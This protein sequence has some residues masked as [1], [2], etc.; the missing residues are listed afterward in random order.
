MS[1]HLVPAPTP[2]ARV[3]HP[4]LFSSP[5]VLRVGASRAALS[6]SLNERT[7]ARNRHQPP[8]LRSVPLSLRLW[9]SP[10]LP[11]M[12]PFAAEWLTATQ[13]GPPSAV[14]G[15]RSYSVPRDW[16]LSACPAVTEA[17][18]P[19]GVSLGPV[20]LGRSGAELCFFPDGLV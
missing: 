18:A 20:H 11:A 14:R 12:F 9:L 19:A 7:K 10:R 8:V 5:L 17:C 3:P 6:P 13:L 15:P 16:V 2:W 4:A 1:A